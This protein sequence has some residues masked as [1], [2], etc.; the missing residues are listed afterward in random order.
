MAVLTLLAWAVGAAPFAFVPNEKSGTITVI[1]VAT[2]AVVGE[3]KA[4]KRPRCITA[5]KDGICCT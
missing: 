5:S 2:D 3:F 1:D 4:G